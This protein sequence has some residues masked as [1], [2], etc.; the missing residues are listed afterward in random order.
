MIELRRGLVVPRTPGLAA[1]EADRSALIGAQNHAGRI[2]G[3]DP[4][5]VVVVTARRAADNR[6]RLTSVFGSVESD[7]WDIDHFAI[8]WVDGDAAEIPCAAGETRVR[9]REH[10]SIA[11]VIRTIKAGLVCL[12][13]RVDALAIGRNVY[14][15]PS[16]IAFG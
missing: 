6:N 2:S 15:N 14:A 9:I 10:P 3:I 11:A 4:K 13:E 7:V 5:L 16:P 12:Q 8:L 1:I